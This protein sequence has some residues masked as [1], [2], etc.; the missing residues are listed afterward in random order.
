L[1]NILIRGR[2]I[3]PAEETNI[4]LYNISIYKIGNNIQFVL[5]TI[6]LPENIQTAEEHIIKSNTYGAFSIQ[7]IELLLDFV[8][9]NLDTQY[10]NELKQELLNIKN[11]LL[12]SANKK[13]PD[14]DF[15]DTRLQMFKDFEYLAF[16]IYTNLATYE[17]L[18]AEQTRKQQGDNPPTLKKV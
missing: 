1:P 5:R 12:V 7:D 15:F 4:E 16:D 10:T 3:I 8:Y 17:E 2:N 6:H 9:K 13:L 11:Q 18:I 14:R